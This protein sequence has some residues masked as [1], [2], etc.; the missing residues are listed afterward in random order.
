MFM[1]KNTQNE[2]LNAEPRKWTNIPSIVARF[3]NETSMRSYLRDNFP[4]LQA[5]TRLEMV[6]MDTGRVTEVVL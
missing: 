1:V 6:D 4:T 3:I 2:Y 5:G